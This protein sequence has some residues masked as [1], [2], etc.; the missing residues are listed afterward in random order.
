MAWMERAGEPGRLIRP[1]GEA[2]A[3]FLGTDVVDLI[4]RGFLDHGLRGGIGIPAEAADAVAT[5]MI[6][7][8][9]VRGEQAPLAEKLAAALVDGV[10]IE[11]LPDGNGP[12]DCD[13][14]HADADGDPS[15]EHHVLCDVA[16][17]H[18]VFHGLVLTAGMFDFGFDRLAHGAV[19]RKIAL[20]GLNG[21]A[22]GTV[23]LVDR[24]N[25]RQ[26][27]S[28]VGRRGDAFDGLVGG[29]EKDGRPGNKECSLN[30]PARET[31]RL[32]FESVPAGDRAQ[33]FDAELKHLETLHHFRLGI[34]DGG[35]GLVVEISDLIPVELILGRVDARGE[36]LG[37]LIE[38]TGGVGE[39]AFPGFEFP[40]QNFHLGGPQ[41]LLALQRAQFPGKGKSLVVEAI[42]V[43]I[44][45]AAE[46]RVFLLGALQ[47][48]NS[49][50]ERGAG[51]FNRIGGDG[52]GM[53]GGNA[54]HGYGD[55]G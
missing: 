9:E 34:T 41:F 19:Q 43:V 48:A 24:H 54:R 3:D 8:G 17:K 13:H 28:G 47:L 27:R 35:G 25:G 38:K 30:R 15:V 45:R 29:G 21:L 11:D 32:A 23:R 53:G 12:A 20:A 40:L 37:V 2:V 16:E 36:R 52:R 42:D 1:L 7:G 26:P 5:S 14:E 46:I 6:D 44:E 22:D 31:K 4:E 10:E 55:C 39:A 49:F 50:L 33:A 51:A 18:D